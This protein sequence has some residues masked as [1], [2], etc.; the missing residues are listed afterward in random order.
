MRT[1]SIILRVAYHSTMLVMVIVITSYQFLSYSGVIMVKDKASTFDVMI[2]L[3][4]AVLWVGTALLSASKGAY[5]RKA[6]GDE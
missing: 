3:A 4:G 1:K 2:A 6:V 5:H